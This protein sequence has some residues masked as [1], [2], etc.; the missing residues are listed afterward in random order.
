MDRVNTSISF[1]GDT[2]HKKN[3]TAIHKSM[4]I[5]ALLERLL[6]SSKA[7]RTIVSREGQ[8]QVR[9]SRSHIHFI[10]FCINFP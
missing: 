7:Q 3:S 10:L 6:F 2:E 9:G 1:E 4:N 5:E 8:F